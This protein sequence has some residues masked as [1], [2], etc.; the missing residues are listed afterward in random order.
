MSEQSIANDPL[1]T[2]CDCV[3]REVSGFSIPSARLE[4]AL[5]LIREIMV[6]IRSMDE[7]DVS[8]VRPMTEFRL[9]P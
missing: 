8:S 5:P 2:A 9:E 4:A 3:L 1:W 6:A 7:V